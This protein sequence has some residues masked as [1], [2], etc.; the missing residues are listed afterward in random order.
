MLPEGRRKQG[1]QEGGVRMFVTG[2]YLTWDIE[3]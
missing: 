3:P 2:G 1:L